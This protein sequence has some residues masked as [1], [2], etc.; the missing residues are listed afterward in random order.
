[1]PMSGSV[2]AAAVE[3]RYISEFTPWQ[4]ATISRLN[5]PDFTFAKAAKKWGKV[6]G[7][8]TVSHIIGTALVVGTLAPGHTAHALT[9]T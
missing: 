3:A 2:L 9:V 1:M 4:G 5:D 6:V 7:I 8:P